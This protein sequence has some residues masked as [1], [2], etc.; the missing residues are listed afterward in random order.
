MNSVPM[1]GRRASDPT[2]N[3]NNPADHQ[4]PVGQRPGKGILVAGIQ[5]VIFRAAPPHQSYPPLGHRAMGFLFRLEKFQTQSR[6]DGARDKKRRKQGDG[7]GE[8]QGN[9]QQL[10]D[11]DDEQDRQEHHDRRDRRGEDRHGHL[12]RR[13]QDRLPAPLTGIE[14]ALD[15]F[16]L[17][18]GIIDQPSDPQGQSAQGKDVQGLSGEIQKNKRHHDRQR[19]RHRNNHGA[20]EIAEED[21]DHGSRQDRPVQ[22]LLHEVVDGLANVDGLVEGDAE[23][24]PRRDADHFRQGGS[25]GVNHFH[26]VGD[27]LFID[28]QVNGPIPVGSNDIGLDVRR[29]HDSAKVSHPHRISLLIDLDDDVVDRL[30]R[31]ELVVGEDVVIEVAGLDIARRQNQVGG[32]DGAHDVKDGQPA[33]IQERGVEI[34]VD[35][36]NLAAF[37]RRRRH[38]RELFDLRGDG[39]EGEV[40]E[41]ALIQIAPGDRDKRDRNIGDVKLDDEGLQDPGGQAVENLG[42]PLHHLHLPDIDIGAPIEP[43]LYG[44]DA[45]LGERLHVLHVGGRA[46]GFFDRIDDALLDVERGRSLVD[47][48]DKRDRHLDIREEI[49]GEALQ[50][51]GAQHHHRQRQHQDADSVSKREER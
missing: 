38:V 6:R 10:G 29:I 22:G 31:S 28:A 23:L 2:K 7:N 37:D 34:D 18:D 41:G 33:G 30:D 46:D 51:G 35:L 19:N 14:V 40:V 15:I 4:F 11:A 17:H 43:D 16:Q 36:T 50:R 39:I 49:D 20:G 5:R 8:R 3:S 1:S 24:H 44:P 45:M 42:D 21:E 12:A 25:E 47:D 26:C 27:W 13:F 9:E 48:P 32:F